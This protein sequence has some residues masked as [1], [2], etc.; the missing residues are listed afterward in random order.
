MGV[1]PNLLSS[2]L[3]LLPLQSISME[4]SL[5]PSPFNSPLHGCRLPS[6]TLQPL[7]SQINQTSASPCSHLPADISR[8]DSCLTTS[9]IRAQLTTDTQGRVHLYGWGAQGSVSTP[10]RLIFSSSPLNYFMQY[11]KP[12]GVKIFPELAGMHAH[13]FFGTI[14][15]NIKVLNP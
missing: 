1:Q 2:N 8:N 10:A 3:Q 13:T 6:V 11:A 9:A 14:K 5:A 15:A 7:L 4:K 12:N